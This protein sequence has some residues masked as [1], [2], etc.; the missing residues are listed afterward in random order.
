MIVKK[1]LVKAHKYN[2]ILVI[3]L[4]LTSLVAIV[5][6]QGLPQVQFL[7]VLCLVFSYL[8]W[9]LL[10]HKL[11]KTLTLEVMLEY[12]LTALLALVVAYGALL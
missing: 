7:V 9:A 4:A 2:L 12:I 11:D 5:R 6:L 3:V 1:V 8:T 10:Y